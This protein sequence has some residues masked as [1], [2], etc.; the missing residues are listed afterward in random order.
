[1]VMCYIGS[2]GEYVGR[3]YTDNNEQD[4]EKVF[5]HRV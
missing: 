5:S 3:E 1:M 2:W 4:A